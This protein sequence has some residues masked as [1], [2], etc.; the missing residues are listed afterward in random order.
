VGA[1]FIEPAL[2]ATAPVELF[3]SASL[4]TLAM[5]VSGLESAR[6]SPSGDALLR[7]ALLLVGR[8]LPRLGSSDTDPEA[9][10]QLV[11][12]AILCGQGT[13]F[14]GGGLVT[15]LGHSL[16]AMTGVDNGVINAIL[17]PHAMQFNAGTV[18]PR[19]A[20][21]LAP[22]QEAIPGGALGDGAGAIG[23]IRTLLRALGTPLALR[24]V[25]VSRDS[26]EV[27][28]NHAMNDWSLA[29][30]PREVTHENILQ[31]LDAAW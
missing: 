22:L 2:L 30:N 1:I 10:I 7:H 26:F 14:T 4:N 9:R 5:A 27:I 3:R 28:A 24:E 31:V 21:V 25:G 16:G 11:H 15:A 19:H 17:L 8:W 12:A 18:A 13:D 23:A 29:N 6:V 20:N